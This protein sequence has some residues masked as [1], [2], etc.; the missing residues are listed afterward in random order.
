MS[1]R[2]G[3]SAFCF[4][5]PSASAIARHTFRMWGGRGRE[6]TRT[7]AQNQRSENRTSNGQRRAVRVHPPAAQVASRAPKSR[8]RTGV[9]TLPLFQ[10][11]TAI[12]RRLLRA[13]SCKG[14]VHWWHFWRHAEFCIQRLLALPTA[15]RFDSVD[16]PPTTQEFG[17]SGKAA[18]LDQVRFHVICGWEVYPLSHRCLA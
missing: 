10:S 5:P 11:L 17:T 12:L 9:L 18:T 4:F 8:D 13:L 3:F 7:G 16:P 15:P 1:S 2:R 14:N 6:R